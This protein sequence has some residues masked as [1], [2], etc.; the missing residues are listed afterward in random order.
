VDPGERF[1]LVSWNR[2]YP[3]LREDAFLRM[4]ASMNGV[5]RSVAR[6]KGVL[7]VDAAQAMPSGPAYFGDFVHF[8]DRGSAVFSRIVADKLAPRLRAQAP[9][10]Q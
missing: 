10:P 8:N 5:M 9:G 3:M 6:D 2:F 4:E 7:L 1:M